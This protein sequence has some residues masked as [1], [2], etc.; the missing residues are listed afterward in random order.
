MSANSPNSPSLSSTSSGDSD[1]PITF[2]L[3]EIAQ[4]NHVANAVAETEEKSDDVE[5]EIAVAD[6][7]FNEPTQAPVQHLSDIDAHVMMVLSSRRKEN[8]TMKERRDLLFS[9]VF[10][11]ST[12]HLSSFFHPALADDHD[13]SILNNS[14]M[15]CRVR[16]HDCRM[17][18][19]GNSLFQLWMILQKSDDIKS[20]DKSLKPSRENT[21]ATQIKNLRHFI[22]DITKRYHFE[23]V[24]KTT[25]KHRIV[26]SSGK[27]SEFL[28]DEFLLNNPNW[29]KEIHPSSCP[30]CNH[31]SIV[32]FEKDEDIV[33]EVSRLKA[34]YTTKLQEFSKLPP[35]KQS[36]GTKPKMPVFP[37]QHM[38]CMCSVNRCRDVTS[39]R[40]CI[41]CEG[42]V[43][44]GMKLN[45]DVET[46]ET[47]C[48]MCRCSCTAFFERMKWTKLKAQ[49]ELDNA[50]KK[51]AIHAARMEKAAGK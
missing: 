32:A 39:G 23:K 31:N 51:K 28:Q 18:F 30:L 13:L 37:K 40:G 8:R 50:E 19:I 5:G 16:K 6:G 12:S 42:A 27:A 22:G 4:T 10:G 33:N 9:F 25:K 41:N 24:N 3:G 48:N 44:L 46:A 26:S 38:I 11:R 17:A 1:V 14:L 36:K 2:D 15:K 47:Q 20:D 43:K 49:V 34:D 35:S 21:E 45:F 7:E 29:F